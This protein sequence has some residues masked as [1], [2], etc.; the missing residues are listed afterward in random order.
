MLIVPGLPLADAEQRCR[1]RCRDCSRLTPIFFSIERLTSAMR[2]LQ[3]DLQRRRR[4]QP[5]DDLSAVADIGLDQAL[6]PPRRPRDVATVPV[7][8]TRLF[9]GVAWI[10]RVS[11]SRGGASRRPSSMLLPT[12]TLAA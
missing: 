10:V 5:A 2:T 9:I 7:S 6:A 4:A 11:A 1:C 8:S 3:H 12:R